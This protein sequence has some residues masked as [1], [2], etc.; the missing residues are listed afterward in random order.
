MRG[1]IQWHGDRGTGKEPH[2]SKSII[3]GVIGKTELVTL[4]TGLSAYTDCNRGR[5][6]VNDF[7]GGTPSAPGTTVNVDERAVIYMKDTVNDSIVTITIPAWD[8]VTNPLEE[9]A[10]GDRIAAAD[11]SAIT[12]LVATATGKTLVGLWGKHVKLT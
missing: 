8:K 10:E 2:T 3:S 4:A 12:A 7:D 5:A 11:V 9:G 6:S 1:A